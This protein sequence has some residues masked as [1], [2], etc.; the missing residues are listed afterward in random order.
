MA[1]LWDMDGTLIDSDPLW[2][3][4]EYGLAEA[5][6][7][8]LNDDASR[9]LEG[10]ALPVCAQV[11]RKAGVNLPDGEIMR[12]LTDRVEAA[13]S[14]CPTLPWAAGAVGLLTELKRC[15][16]PSV[17][18]TGSPMC[19]ARR[20]LA[21]APPGA[22]IGAVT[23]EDPLPAKPAPDRYLAA[24][25]IAGCDICEC[26]IFED[27]APGL[28]AAVSSGAR[29]VAVTA[30]ARTAAPESSS[31]ERIVDYRECLFALPRL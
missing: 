18:V 25:G 3:A 16:I 15:G 12:T 7:V 1:V 27:S 31:Y 29:V 17:L 13:L 8:T 14:V 21:A 24:A 28:K 11:L 26:L 20:V 9:A 5:Y 23:G 10:A 19:I 4:A 6:G 2:Y 22:F 30:L